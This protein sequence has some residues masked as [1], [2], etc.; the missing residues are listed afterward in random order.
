M[1]HLYVARHGPAKKKKKMPLGVA[2][3][4]SP[5]AFCEEEEA[6]GVANAAAGEPQE[7]EDASG[8][9]NATMDEPH[10]TSATV[11][12]S[13]ETCCPDDSEATPV[14]PA[15]EKREPSNESPWKTRR[16]SVGPLTMPGANNFVNASVRHVG[17]EDLLHNKPFGG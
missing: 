8:A 7:G 1:N 10:T 13:S 9:A 2:D 14:T 5:E 6:S 3:A 11:L 15:P 4:A 12:D 17:R 16:I